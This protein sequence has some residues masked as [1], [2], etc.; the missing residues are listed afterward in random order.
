MAPEAEPQFEGANQDIV[1][2]SELKPGYVLFENIESI[3]GMKPGYVLSLSDIEKIQSAHDVP[4]ELKVLKTD[5]PKTSYKKQIPTEKDIE[6]AELTEQ[7]RKNGLFTERGDQEIKKVVDMK[8]DF[9]RGEDYEIKRDEYKQQQI[10]KYDTVLRKIHSHQK[11]ET[12]QVIDDYAKSA[13]DMDG[14][15]S[16][17]GKSTNELVARLDHYERNGELFIS[18]ALSQKKIFPSFVEEIVLDFINDVG[19]HLARALFT[20]VSKIDSYSDFLGAHSLQ[21]M[22]VALITALEMTKMIKEKSDELSSTDLNTFLAISK[23]FYSLEDLINLGIAA[24]LHDIEIKN[25]FPNL[26]YNEQTGYNWDSIMDLHPSNGFHI[27]KKLPIDFDVQRAVYQHHERFD[28]SGYPN[29]LFP[30]FFSKYTPVLMFAEHYVENTTP[31]PFQ[32]HM[33]HPRDFLVDLL[34]NHRKKFD[35]DVIYAFIRSA[36]LFPVGSWLLLSDGHIGIVM[37]VNRNK[38]EKPIIKAFF[39]KHLE[40]INPVTIDLSQDEEITIVKPIDLYTI[41]KIAGESFKF[42]Y[43]DN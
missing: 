21:V 22:I 29:G 16:L 15:E 2:K 27:C 43:S 26:K 9:I 17:D 18:A 14:I 36:S 32:P 24:L 41:K 7:E 1:K 37:D 25:K 39:D 34:S 38:L 4:E 40:R 33:I 5:K 28:G 12:L 23:K 20:S 42:I 11:E 10:K 19:Y 35:G 31:N 3:P 13:A 8:K 30:R 6:K